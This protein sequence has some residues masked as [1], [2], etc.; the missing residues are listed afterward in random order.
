MILAIDGPAG[1]GKSTIARAIAKTTGMFYL[2]SGNFYRGI[3]WLVF[4]QDLD[5]ENSAGVIT[6]AESCTFDL[7]DDR[8]YLNGR[9]VEDYLHTDSVDRWVATHSAIPKVREVVNRNLRHIALLIDAVVEG[10]DITTVVFPDAD[11]K[12]FLD[13]SIETR[14][15]RRLKQGV[16]NLTFEE[17]LDSIRQRDEIDRNKKVGSLKIAEDAMYL[18]TSV[19]TI[20]EVCEK[21]VQ[22]IRTID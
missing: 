10:R 5:P 19:L 6:V 9:D 17:I 13:A 8:L 15:K 16:S 4:H 18:D 20:D 1:V 12:I 22:K 11:L 7:K 14:A 21:V 3:T 2:N